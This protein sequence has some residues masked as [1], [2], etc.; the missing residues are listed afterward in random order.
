[1]AARLTD[2]AVQAIL[3]VLRR[4]GPAATYVVKNRLNSLPAFERQS[5]QQILRQL[6]SLERV[7]LVERVSTSYAVMISWKAV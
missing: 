1:M 7:G 4:H 5:T 2:E 6:K 3:N